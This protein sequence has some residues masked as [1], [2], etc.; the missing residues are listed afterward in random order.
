MGV[1][2]GVCHVLVSIICY[3]LTYQ[4]ITFL[5]ILYGAVG[6]IIIAIYAIY[7]FP[8]EEQ[9]TEASVAY[10]YEEILAENYIEVREIRN[11]S[12]TE[13]RHARRVSDI[14]YKYAATLGLKANLAAAAGFYYRLGTKRAAELCFSEELITIIG[15]YNGEEKL[16]SSP[17]SALVHIVDAMLIKLE[18][19]EAQLGTSQWNR[20]VLIYQA[21][22]EFSSSGLYDKSGLSINAFLK[23]REMLAKE[24]LL[25]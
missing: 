12:P 10:H 2:L 6:G 15:E 18:L 5:E 16:P 22:N 20:E 13:Y 4:K 7:L 17:E 9:R 23:V 14:C 19:L 25:S 24:E 1:M 21:L 3:Y 8:K 11:Y